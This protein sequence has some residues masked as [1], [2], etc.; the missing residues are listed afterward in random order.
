VGTEGVRSIKPV[1]AMLL[2][3]VSDAEAAHVK[4]E[5]PRFA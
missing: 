1:A 4:R 5:G 3:D 2:I